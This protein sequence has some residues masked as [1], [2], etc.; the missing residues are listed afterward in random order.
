MK[1]IGFIILF[2]AIGATT[3]AQQKYYM[4]AIDIDSSQNVTNGA[5]INL[6]NKAIAFSSSN[7]KFHEF[8][9]NGYYLA[10]PGLLLVDSNLQHST[11]KQIYLDG[12]RM[13]VS[14]VTSLGETYF[15]LGWLFKSKP[16]DP[17]RIDTSMIFL[18]KRN[19]QG[20]TL[21]T[22]RFYDPNFCLENYPRSINTTS[23]SNLLFVSYV[24]NYYD[25][26]SGLWLVKVDTNGNKLWERLHY[27]RYAYD[28]D[29]AARNYSYIKYYGDCM[30]ETADGGFLLGGGVQNTRDADYAGSLIM[31]F[32]ASGSLLWEKDFFNKDEEASDSYFSSCVRLQDGSFVFVGYYGFVSDHLY[33]VYGLISFLNIR[34][35]G[36]VL[37]QRLIKVNKDQLVRH[38]VQRQNGDLLLTGWVD[39]TSAFERVDKAFIYCISPDGR[40][41]RWQRKYKYPTEHPFEEAIVVNF[42]GIAELFDKEIIVVGTTYGIDNTFPYNGGLDQDLLILRADSNGCIDANSCKLLTEVEDEILQS[43][44]F[45]LSPNPSNGI[46]KILTNLQ[47]NAT[48]QLQIVDISGRI[49]LEYFVTDLQQEIDLSNLPAGLYFARLITGSEQLLQKIILH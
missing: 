7:L 17:T 8:D 24:R 27:Y 14:K 21:W 25:G 35:N 20:D 36:Q 48:M 16:Y 5:Y 23:D 18:V 29:T 32:D 13:D 9:S 31:R 22:K 10:K 4:K 11:S 2:L 38:M 47:W 28:P 37:H 34:A 46:V 3:R 6:K 44:Y 40:E 43:A 33:G 26:K 12:F 45:Y 19:S 42:N 39:D 1:G 30:V 41:L 49:V 15:E